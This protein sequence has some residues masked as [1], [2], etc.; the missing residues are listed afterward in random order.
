MS[1]SIKPRM[2]LRDLTQAANV[3]VRTVRYYISESL[4]PPPEDSGPNACYTD[5]HLDRLRL[6]SRLKDL[7]L[8]LKAIRRFLDGMDDERV[9]YWNA[10]SAADLA[11]E[12]AARRP[13]DTLPANVVPIRAGIVPELPPERELTPVYQTVITIWTEDDPAGQ[14]LAWLAERADRNKAVIIRRLSERIADPKSH[15]NRGE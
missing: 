4:L 3:S 5:R 7:Y 12:I 1:D 8:P 10:A 14:P 11:A 2:S 13:S 6:I 15:A 9:A